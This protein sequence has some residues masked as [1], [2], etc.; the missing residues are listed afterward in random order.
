MDR[1]QSNL[2]NF[3]VIGHINQIFSDSEGY[4]YTKKGVIRAVEIPDCPHCGCNV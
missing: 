2:K 4:E 3:S 1:I